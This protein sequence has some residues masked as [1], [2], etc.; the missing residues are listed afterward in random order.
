[1]PVYVIQDRGSTTPKGRDRWVV[2][3]YHS[4]G[5]STGTHEECAVPVTL[6]SEIPTWRL[7]EEIAHRLDVGMIV[8]DRPI[9]YAVPDPSDG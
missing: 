1:M 7:M 2:T 4:D 6:L 8:E 5:V 3:T 9:P